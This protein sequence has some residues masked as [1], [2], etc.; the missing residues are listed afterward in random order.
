VVVTDTLQV[1]AAVDIHEHYRF[2][3]VP[4]LAAALE[5]GPDVTFVCNPSSMHLSVALEAVRAGSHVFIEKPLS[6]RMDGVPELIEETERRG[7]VG[8]VGFQ[9]RFHPGIVRMRQLLAEGAIGNLVAVRAVVGDYM[10]DYHPYEDYRETYNARRDLGGGV[11]LSLIHEL[12]YLMLLF[13]EPVRL[14]ALGGHFSDLK[15]DVEDIASMLF[16]CRS[17]DRPLPV[18]LQ[19]DFLQKPA[20]R[21]CE[22]VGDSGKIVLDLTVPRLVR[23]GRDGSALERAEWSDL[24]RN[25]LFLE[26]MRRFLGAC[27][28][29][30]EPGCSLADGARSLV[31]AL[32]ARRSIETGALVELDA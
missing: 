5:E 2:R 3:I 22:V 15:I 1:D 6:D 26:E 14:F 29:E 10:P 24:Q 21:N 7:L 17:G 30:G 28:G 13:G 31:V 23:Y 20:V 27:R 32:A 9:I 25:A 19:L 8:A 16:D 11:L 12:D 4:T 18:S